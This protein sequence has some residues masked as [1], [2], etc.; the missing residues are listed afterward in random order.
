MNTTHAKAAKITAALL[1]SLCLIGFATSALS[2]ESRLNA[3]QVQGALEVAC[4]SPR[5]PGQQEIARLFEIENFSQTYDLRN[6]LQHVVT[7]ACHSGA[8]RVRFAFDKNAAEDA[9]RYVALS[10]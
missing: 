4:E 1:A 8:D 7:R 3:I 6:R 5:V 2:A 9:L 10:D